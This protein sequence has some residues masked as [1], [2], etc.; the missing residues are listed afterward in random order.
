MTAESPTQGRTESPCDSTGLVARAVSWLIVPIL[1]RQ[2]LVGIQD[3][4]GI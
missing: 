4:I 2:Q 1:L 3:L